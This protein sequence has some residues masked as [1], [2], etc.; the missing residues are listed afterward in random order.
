MIRATDV[1]AGRIRTTDLLRVDPDLLPQGR[2]PYL[3]AAEIIVV[4]SGAYT[5]DSAIIPTELE[6]A[7]AGYDMVATV[8]RASPHFVAYA[9]LSQYVLQDQIHLLSLRAAQP[10][11]NAEELGSII[12]MLP[13]SLREQERIVTYLDAICSAIDAAVAAKRHQ[14]QALNSLRESLV[15]GVITRGV[16]TGA[17]TRPVNEEWIRE[18]PAHWE[19]C[20]IKRIVSRVDYGISKSTEPDGRHPVLKMGHIQHGEIDFR[21][22]DFV[23]EVTSDLLLETGDL[24]YNRTNSPDQVGKAA[25]FRR[26]R[27]DEVTFASYLVRLRTNHLANP[28][29][30]NYV[31]NCSRFL[32]F[33][34]RLAIPSVQQSNLNSTRYCRILIPKPPIKEQREIAAYLDDRMEETTRVITAIESQIITLNE[35]RK[36][37][38][39]ECVT[40]QRRI[41]EEDLKRVRAHG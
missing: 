37:L 39:H 16:R 11:L 23:D 12:L 26:G 22:L 7:V 41:S 35:Y 33:A 17:K 6:G 1:D 28:Y 34:R 32:S 31:V 14:I 13:P 2:N 5:G 30:L 8:T 21:H 9:L 25:V 3:K 36:S 38:I 20:R 29:F 15:E 18:I 10:H 27:T 40:G 4:R 24:L 19:V